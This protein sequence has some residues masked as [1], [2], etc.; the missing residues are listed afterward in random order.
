MSA[1]LKHFIPL[2]V[3]KLARQGLDRFV[4]QHRLRYVW[5]Q[6]VLA[7]YRGRQRAPTIDLVALRNALPN[8]GSVPVR[9]Q[10]TSAR[11]II[12]QFPDAARRQ[13]NIA[14]FEGFALDDA[15]FDAETQHSEMWSYAPLAGLIAVFA[16]MHYDQPSVL[17][18]GCG[19]AHLFYFLRALGIQNYVGLDGN[20]WLVK[21]NPFLHGYNQHFLICNL[22]EEVRLCLNDEPMR[23]DVVCAFEVLEHIREDKIDLFFC[24]LRN[25]MHERSVAFCTASLQ[26]HFDVHVL[27]EDRDWWLDRFARAGLVRHSDADALER[28][29]GSHH[30]FNWNP[31]ISNIFALEV[32]TP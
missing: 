10:F 1:S 11:A 29:I 17:D 31:R 5:Y 30:P 26:A 13:Q 22:Q 9:G 25:H 16:H 12:D 19:P 15:V 24:T 18:V 4:P 27:V 21:L 6:L 28:K 23:F 2:S 8:S 32:R 7:Q 14:G 3:R 20:P